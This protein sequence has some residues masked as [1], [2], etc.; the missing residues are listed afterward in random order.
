MS[1]KPKT[2]EEIF[3]KKEN[4]HKHILD[5]PDT[6]IGSIDSHTKELWILENDELTKKKISFVPSLFKIFD[7]IIVNARDQTIRD[8]TCQNIKISIDKET[9]S[10]SVYNDG[11]DG[12]PIVVHKDYNVYIPQMIFT[13]LMT[14]SNYEQKGKI[15]G[16]KN[17]FGAKLTNIYSKQFEIKIVDK[18]RKKSYYQ[19]CKDNMYKINDPVIETSKDKSS[20]MITF[21]PDYEKFGLKGM[22]DDIYSLFCKRVYDVAGCTNKN[23]KVYLNDEEIK[24]KSFEDYVGMYVKDNTIIYEEVNERWRVALV[25]DSSAGFNQISY[26]NGICTYQGGT[27]VTYVFDQIAKKLINYIN[28]KHKGINVKPSHIKDNISLFIDCVI[29]DPGF[30]SQ[31]KDTLTTQVD[32]FGSTCDISEKFIKRIIKDTGLID[33]VIRFA[34]FKEASSLKKTDGKKVT[35]LRDIPKLKDATDVGTRNSKYCKLI[36]TEGDS[37]MNFAISGL[38]IIGCERYG[39]FPLRGKPLNVR[40]ATVEQLLKN[41]EFTYVKKILGLKQGKEYT[42]ENISELR[43]GGVLVITDQDYDGSHIKGLIMNMFH[44]FWPSLLKIDGF[45][46]SL[47]TPIIKAFKKNTEPIIFYTITEYKKWFDKQENKDDWTIKY[48]KGLGTSTEKEA[49]EC[50][51]EFDKKKINYVWE[52]DENDESKSDTTLKLV[53]EKKNVTKRKELLS[54]YDEN[55]VLES[56]GGNIPFSDFFHKDMIHFMNYDNIRSIPSVCDGQKPSTRKVLFGT[57]LKKISTEIK[58]AQLGAYIAEKTAYHHGEQSLYETI[59][60]MAQ[61]FVGSNNINLLMPIGN[62]GSRSESGKDFASPRYIFT[63]LNLLTNKIFRKEDKDILKFKYEENEKIEPE[64]YAPI[65]PMILV[66]GSI[67]IGTGYSTNIPCFN[68]KDICN[69]LLKMIKGAEPERI[70][71]WYRKFKGKITQIHDEKRKNDIMYQVS[72]TYEIVD[73]KNGK[74]IRITEI[75][76]GESI[77]SYYTKLCDMIDDT[78]KTKNDTMKTK[79]DKKKKQNK[80]IFRDVVNESGINN[81]NIKVYFADGFLQQFDKSDTIEKEL[82]LIT[83]ISLSN[84]HAYNEDHKIVKYNNVQEIF[85]DFYSFRMKLYKQRKRHILK[86]LENQMNLLN[87]KVKFIEDYLSGNIVIKGRKKI[88]IIKDLQ[89]LKYPPIEQI[90]GTDITE[91]NNNNDEQEEDGNEAKSYSYLL[92]MQLLSLTEERILKLKKERNDKEKEFNDYVNTSEEKL[93]EKEIKEFLTD[94]DKYLEELE[95]EEN[96]LGKKKKT[97][98]TTKGKKK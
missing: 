68:P 29:E 25:Y 3:Q 88:A 31:I 98:K 90:M 70:H 95:A 67:G 7:E 42:A 66:N 17:G 78:M 81:V 50:F 97:I 23:V 11:E 16:G 60:G 59:V 41:K 77:Y 86:S 1:K 52:T 89:K 83:T 94:Y 18:K 96:S 72:G 33:E 71:P 9:G 43:Y 20:T 4:Q 76:V 34:E 48:Y 80:K 10:I 39:V 46:Q 32:K 40:E 12:I 58:V 15:V 14:S 74:Y 93:W 27:H 57:I 62:F 84:M 24:I 21:V 55:N 54:R 51:D 85:Y 91:E 92:S 87:Y 73:D 69:N 49:Q 45:I 2:I 61:T 79:N 75:P 35:S 30:N 8:P 65:I 82:K 28:T 56:K 26:V 47:A 38:E 19:L 13:E 6:Y 44:T 63:K 64:A 36:L 22:T 37:A 53:F 5:L